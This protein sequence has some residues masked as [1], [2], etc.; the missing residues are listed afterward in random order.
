MTTKQNARLAPGADTAD[1][2]KNTHIIP[3]RGVHASCA[4]CGT[5]RR[6]DEKWSDLC[7]TCRAWIRAGE[8]MNRAAS[9]LREVC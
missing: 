9:L 8:C 4:I 3:F 5:F 7:L 1:H 6:P 2:T